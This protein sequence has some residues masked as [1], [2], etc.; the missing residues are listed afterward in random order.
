MTARAA[1]DGQSAWPRLMS[2]GLA[3]RY[4]DVSETTFRD[5][6]SEG[7]MPQPIKIGGSVRWDRSEID[8][9]IDEMPRRR[10]PAKRG[11][12]DDVRVA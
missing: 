5:W 1:I 4:A 8:R 6:V 7:F 11:A 3:A 10:E 9:A 12:L 2:S